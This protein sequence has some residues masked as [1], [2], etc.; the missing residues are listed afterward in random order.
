MKTFKLLTLSFAI[1]ATLTMSSCLNG[2]DSSYSI[3]SKFS[4]MINAVV[5][6]NGEVT[7]YGNQSVNVTWKYGTNVADLDIVGL[8]LPNGTSYPTVKIEDAT[9]SIN[10]KGWMDVTLTD[11]QPST[12]SGYSN[13]LFNRFNL[14]T[15]N[16][17]YENLTFPPCINISYTINNEY[18]VYAIPSEL[19]E[20]GTTTVI[21]QNGATYTQGGD[22]H[23]IYYV[24]LDSSAKKGYLIIQGAK[25]AENMPAMNMKFANIPFTVQRNGVMVMTI[26]ELVPSLLGE[27]DDATKP[28]TPAPN[29]PITNFSATY[30]ANNG[31]NITFDCT[32]MNQTY[33]VN[34]VC[35][36]PTITA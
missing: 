5:D 36:Y 9:W 32:V 20:I 13:I 8:K 23:T 12:S 18:T 19:I 35:D 31:L 4:D 2:N 21:D 24:G 16:R 22:T 30:N 33:H 17:T 34:V 26:N 15:V 6:G 25:F 29:F 3:E 11:Y 14:Q 10:S 27:D 1:G 7:L 28:G